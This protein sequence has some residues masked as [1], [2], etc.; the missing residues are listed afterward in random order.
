MMKLN[1]IA[2]CII[3]MREYAAAG[4]NANSK[5]QN[6]RKYKAT[7]RWVPNQGCPSYITKRKI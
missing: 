2:S 1:I 5:K 4:W 6:L 3:S 7:I